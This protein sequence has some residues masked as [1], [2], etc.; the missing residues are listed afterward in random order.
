[1]NFVI[2][3]DKKAIGWYRACW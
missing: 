3:L 1:M 2:S